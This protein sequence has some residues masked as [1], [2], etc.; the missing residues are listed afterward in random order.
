VLKQLLE[1]AKIN[2]EEQVALI[3]RDEE[4]GDIA[5]KL[6]AADRAKLLDVF[7]ANMTAAVAYVPKDEPKVPNVAPTVEK[8][9]NVTSAQAAIPK[10]GTFSGDEPLG[11]GEITYDQWKR[12]VDCL[13]KE[14]ISDNVIMLSVRRSL[15]ST[16]SAVLLNLGVDIDPKGVIEK[17][18]VVFGNILPSEMLLEDFYTARQNEKESIIAWGCRIESLLNKAKEQGTI[19]G[20]EDMAKT[21][22]WSGIRDEKIKSA[23]RHKFDAGESFQELLKNAR[24]LEH[25]FNSQTVKVKTQ[26]AEISPDFKALLSR[27]ESMEKKMSK[28]FE[29]KNSSSAAKGE[30]SLFCRYCKRTNHNIEDCKIL[31]RKDNKKKGNG[32]QSTPRTGE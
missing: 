8:P 19:L 22:F 7:R 4:F 5:N 17:F 11:K 26:S 18:D 12:E 16:A 29:K 20:T 27:M 2:V 10:L 23:L 3:D 24:M 6:D 15:K 9:Q 28:L 32:E 14:G 30:S 31:A 13:V 1:M 25:E 21:K